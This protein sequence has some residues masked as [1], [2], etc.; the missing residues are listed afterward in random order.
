V[1]GPRHVRSAARP[2]WRRQADSLLAGGLALLLLTGAA[3]VLLVSVPVIA[4]GQ[5]LVHDD[6][7]LVVVTSGGAGIAPG[8]RVSV[9]WGTGS[10]GG[11]RADGTVR[12]V[13]KGAD[14]LRR[15]QLPGQGGD[16]LVAEAQ[17]AEGPRD[18]LSGTATA[19]VGSRPLVDLFLG[20]GVER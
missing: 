17:L 3:I 4:T 20:R 1:S 16:V 5:A 12:K 2:A 7:V 15:Y 8:T 14:A 6:T 9:V 13:E 18:G 19:Y 10:D 11:D